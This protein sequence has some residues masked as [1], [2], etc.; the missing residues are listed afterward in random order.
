[1][2]GEGTG[3]STQ[4]EPFTALATVEMKGSAALS[5]SDKVTLLRGFSP[6]HAVYREITA[7]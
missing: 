3:S 4:L 2:W 1:M 6:P 5:V 7:R